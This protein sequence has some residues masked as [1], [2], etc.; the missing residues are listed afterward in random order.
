MKTDKKELYAWRNFQ[1]TAYGKNFEFE[2]PDK[3]WLSGFR[4]GVR[5]SICPECRGLKFIVSRDLIDICE[6]C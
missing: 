1:R 3:A 4:A 2:L 6:A 5:H